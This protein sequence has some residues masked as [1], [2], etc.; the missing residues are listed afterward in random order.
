MPIEATACTQ[1]E[2]KMKTYYIKFVGDSTLTIEA[3]GFE[4][5]HNLIHFYVAPKGINSKKITFVV[6]P[7]NLL[8]F[9][10]G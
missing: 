7:D 5:Y 9:E 10:E 2:K 8:Y 3:D 4:I 1:E 6:P